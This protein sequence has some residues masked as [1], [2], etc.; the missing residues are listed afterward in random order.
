MNAQPLAIPSRSDYLTVQ[1][2]RGR[3]VL[4]VFPAQY[5]REILWAHDIAPMEIWDPPLEPGS[6]PAHL[7]PYICA[8]VRQ[9][10]ELVLRGGA[11]RLDGLLVPHT[12]DSL[13]N[14]ASLL[15]DYLELPVPVMFF[16]H[17]KEPFRAS[18][19]TY[20][21]RQLELLDQKLAQR[22]GPRRDGALEQAV[23]WGQKI[24][25]L[26]G[27]AYSLRAQGQLNAP[28]AEFYRVLR[29]GE[30]LHPEDFIPLLEQ[31]LAATQGPAPVGP[32]VLLSGVLPNPKELLSL[33]DEQGAGVGHDDFLSLSRRLLGPAS[34]AADP[35]DALSEQYFALPPCSSRGSAISL[36]LEWLQGLAQASGARGVIFYVVKFCEPELFDVPPL[37]AGLKEQGLAT[38][39]LE[40]ELNQGVSGQI[41]TRVEAF[42]EMLS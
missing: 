8:V 21:R 22:F 23:A 20:Y 40:V 17:P 41:A 10:L 5:P 25:A 39:S 2:Q 11:A 36:R 7:Q 29:A 33:L 9:G 12:C 27:Q 34:Q 1:K 19:R 31:F 26:A 24:A 30:Y 42:L 15:K 18:A 35:W 32:V 3:K 4:G 16:Y 37:A 6:A 14:L 38:L 28:A 13:Q